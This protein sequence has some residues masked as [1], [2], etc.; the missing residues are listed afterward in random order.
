LKPFRDEAVEVDEQVAAA[1]VAAWLVPAV[2]AVAAWLDH[3]AA[4]AAAWL[5]RPVEVVVVGFP[6]A[7]SKECR[8]DQRPGPACQASQ[9][10]L[11]CPTM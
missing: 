5:D 11:V 1:A 3:P 6:E 7:D 10:G 4:A 2:A 9:P 8:R